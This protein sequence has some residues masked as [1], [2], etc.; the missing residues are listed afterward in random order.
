MALSYPSDSDSVDTPIAS[1]IDLYIQKLNDTGLRAAIDLFNIDFASRDL[2]F[3]YA[4]AFESRKS[5][6][7][8]I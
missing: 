6:I 2:D 8:V 4:Q 5:L 7:S 3:T 1:S